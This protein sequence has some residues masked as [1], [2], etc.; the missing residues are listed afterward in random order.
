[1]CA[2]GRRID[3]VCGVQEVLVVLRHH[4]SLCMYEV[5]DFLLNCRTNQEV[6]ETKQYLFTKTIVPGTKGLFRTDCSPV[7]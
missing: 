4:Q 2:V 7:F 1:M 3:D 6:D 5:Y